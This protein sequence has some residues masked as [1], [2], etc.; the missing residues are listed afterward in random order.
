MVFEG[1]KKVFQTSG[2]TPTWSLARFY[3]ECFH[4]RILNVLSGNKYIDM[5][6]Y[7][8]RTLMYDG[9]QSF[10]KTLIWSCL[11][12]STDEKNQISGLLWGS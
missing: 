8:I 7:T 10:I 4:V 3:I 6:I 5:C 9:L 12:P 11:T 2:K 1:E